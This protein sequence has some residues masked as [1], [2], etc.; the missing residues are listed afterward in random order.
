M[1]AR[2][3]Q[4]LESQ[5]MTRND[6]DPAPDLTDPDIPDPA[7]EITD[8]TTFLSTDHNILVNQTPVKPVRHAQV[9]TACSR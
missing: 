5:E 2:E 4:A 3:G 8:P 6:T 1:L 9:S 7:L